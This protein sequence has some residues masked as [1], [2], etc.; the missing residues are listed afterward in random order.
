M[1]RRR[2]YRRLTIGTCALLCVAG[3]LITIGWFRLSGSALPTRGTVRVAGLLQPVDVQIDTFGIPQV[4][5]AA[6]TDLLRAL[7]YLHATDRLW[8]ME[9]FR[10]VAAGRLSE[11][12]GRDLVDTD[13]FLRTLDLWGQPSVRPGTSIRRSTNICWPTRRA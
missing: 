9:F 10:H 13:R 6:E 11:I 5:A 7:G 2:T 12:F 3:L 4:T 1:S 8:Q